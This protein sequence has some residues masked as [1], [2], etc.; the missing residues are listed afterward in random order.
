MTMPPALAPF[1]AKNSARTG[2]DLSL[3]ERL[4]FAAQHLRMRNR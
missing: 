3:R 2:Q 4:G 1:A